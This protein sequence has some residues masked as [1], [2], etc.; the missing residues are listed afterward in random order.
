MLDP[1]G[2]LFFMVVMGLAYAYPLAYLLNR[3]RRQQLSH[4]KLEHYLEERSEVV[5]R[6]AGQ[7]TGGQV[8]LEGVVRGEP[9]LRTPVSER[10]AIAYRLVGLIEPGVTPESR[11]RVVDFSEVSD[12]EVEDSSGERV[13]VQGG[14]AVLLAWPPDRHEKR[15]NQLSQSTRDLVLERHPDRD[16][17]HLESQFMIFWS[18][19]LLRPG[20]FVQVIGRAEQVPS[21]AGVG[22]TYRVAPQRWLIKAPEPMPLVI[23]VGPVERLAEGLM[24]SRLELPG[25]LITDGER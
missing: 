13:L 6:T 7:L 21:A 18:E 19:W 15:F 9:G 22:T 4:Y 5:V 11:I 12:F 10:S 3:Y 8:R 16:Q 2:A 23:L 20:Q 14:P 24:R 17:Q 1:L 25:R